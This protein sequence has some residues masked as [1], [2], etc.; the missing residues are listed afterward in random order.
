MGHAERQWLVISLEV[1]M[2]VPIAPGEAIVIPT[3]DL[4]KAHP[5]LEQATGY[6]AFAAKEFRLRLDVHHTVVHTRAFGSKPVHVLD[7]LR[8]IGKVQCIG[9]AQ[10]HGP[11]QFISTDP[12]RQSVIPFP[13]RRMGS[14]QS[15]QQMESGLIA[16]GGNKTTLRRAQI[17]DG[18]FITRTNDGT[19]VQGGEK[20]SSPILCSVRCETAVVGQNHKGGE[21]VVFTAEGIG[22][23]GPGAGKSGKIKSGGL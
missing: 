14:I 17:R 10:L 8:L 5:S 9:G 4:D 3:P 1:L 11:G 19:L 20:G 15:V 2:A 16:L 7:I 23:P 18:I 21:I 22:H 6:Q 13:L 12:G